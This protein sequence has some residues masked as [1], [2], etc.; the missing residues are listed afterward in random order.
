MNVSGMVQGVAS[1]S[2]AHVLERQ[3][4]RRTGKSSFRY[5]T[6]V[7]I[8]SSEHPNPHENRQK[9]VVHLPQNGTTG[10]DSQPYEASLAPVLCSFPRLLWNLSRYPGQLAMNRQPFM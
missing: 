8:L 1:D 6:W 4:K 9:W 10:F 7:K 2:D 5:G 3:A